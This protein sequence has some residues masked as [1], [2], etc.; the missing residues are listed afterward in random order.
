M[1][2]DALNEMVSLKQFWLAC[3]KCTDSFSTDYGPAPAIAAPLAESDK[4]KLSDNWQKKHS[5]ITPSDMMLNDRLL[6]QLYRE[7]HAKPRKLSVYIMQNLRTQSAIAPRRLLAPTGRPV[8]LG[9]GHSRRRFH[10]YGNLHLPACVLP[11]R[12]VGYS[13]DTRL[14]HASRLLRQQPRSTS[15]TK[16]VL[17]S[18]TWEAW[19]VKPFLHSTL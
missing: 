6:D 18:K 19:Y 7:L 8:N 5:Y 11:L 13:F 3:R 16:S 14:V 10:K 4:A 12:C 9:K 17:T 2:T 1:P 15:Q